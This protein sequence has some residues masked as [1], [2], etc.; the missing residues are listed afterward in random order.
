VQSPGDGIQFGKGIATLEHKR[1][2]GLALEDVSLDIALI[3]K[4]G[5]DA[6]ALVDVFS[7]PPAADCLLDELQV[8]L[9]GDDGGEVLDQVAPDDDAD[10]VHEQV[11]ASLEPHLLVL[12]VELLVGGEVGR[13]DGS[14]DL[15]VFDELVG[16][17]SFRGFVESAQEDPAR[18]EILHEQSLL[19]PRAEIDP[20]E[21]LFGLD[22]VLVDECV[23]ALLE[24][25]VVDVAGVD[26]PVVFGGVDYA[27]DLLV[28]VEGQQDGHLHHVHQRQELPLDLVVQG[29]GRLVGL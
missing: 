17:C 1:P 7:A 4:V 21:A 14:D 25:E 19:P 11:D 9:V 23:L 13:L 26:V 27:L 18:D 12:L 24:E 8:E 3:D 16:V 20:E 6:D 28:V 22:E 2:L 29:F 10:A 5:D 15:H